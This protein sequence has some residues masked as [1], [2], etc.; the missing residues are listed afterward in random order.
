MCVPSGR[1]ERLSRLFRG[2]ELII[3]QSVRAITKRGVV[4]C[5][6]TVGE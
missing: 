1:E 3:N 5:T 2:N 4:A 6:E